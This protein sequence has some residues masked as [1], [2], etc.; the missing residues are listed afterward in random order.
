MSVRRRG[1]ATRRV[2]VV[3]R[4]SGAGLLFGFL[5]LLAIGGAA[6]FAYLNSSTRSGKHVPQEPE[7]ASRDSVPASPSD[8]IVPTAASNPQLPENAAP[9]KSQATPV[10]PPP[11]PTRAEPTPPTQEERRKLERTLLEGVVEAAKQSC[12][13]CGGSGKVDGANVLNAG[14]ATCIFCNGQGKPSRQIRAWMAE[15]LVEA[16]K[17]RSLPFETTQHLVYGRVKAG[18]MNGKWQG[19]LELQGPGSLHSVH[20]SFSLASHPN[21]ADLMDKVAPGNAVLVLAFMLEPMKT[22]NSPGS[23]FLSECRLLKVGP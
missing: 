22:I 21:I 11:P 17:G 10:A 7:S 13:S 9:Q 1:H 18:G 8:P 23:V 3:R 16:R 20:C 15:D 12:V 4:S 2:V 14:P 6:A 5:G 19:W